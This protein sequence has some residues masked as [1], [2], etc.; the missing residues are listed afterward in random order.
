[1][2][3]NII[4][5]I[6]LG[7]VGLAAFFLLSFYPP[8]SDKINEGTNEIKSFLEKIGTNKCDF[9]NKKKFELELSG[10]VKNVTQNNNMIT[11]TVVSRSKSLTDVITVDL[12]TNNVVSHIKVKKEPGSYK[13]Y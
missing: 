12:C 3:K 5:I 4:L 8:K 10:A 13:D 11:I 2:I 1:M 6:I 9:V 7:I